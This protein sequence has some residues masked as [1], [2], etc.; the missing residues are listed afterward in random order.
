MNCAECNDLEDGT[1]M[2]YAGDNDLKDGKR[3]PQKEEGKGNEV[4][5]G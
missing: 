5:K 2:N 1:D 4:G 3:V